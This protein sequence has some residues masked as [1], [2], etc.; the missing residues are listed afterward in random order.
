MTLIKKFMT[1]LMQLKIINKIKDMKEI[2]VTIK[3]ENETPRKIVV[4]AESKEEASLFF[5]TLL[6]GDEVIS[7]DYYVETLSK[8]QILAG[9]N[10]LK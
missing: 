5:E 4:K 2:I 10:K 9:I 1:Q 6:K 7:T 3:I 8:D